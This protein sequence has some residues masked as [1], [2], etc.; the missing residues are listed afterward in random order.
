MSKFVQQ[1]FI[2]GKFF[3]E[4]WQQFFQSLLPKLSRHFFTPT[5]LQDFQTQRIWLRPIMDARHGHSDA[6]R[7][8]PSC[9]CFPD[10]QNVP[11]HH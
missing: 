1:D 3:P 4:T 6:Q 5:T 11:V 8:E 10:A 7:A 9:T 2:R